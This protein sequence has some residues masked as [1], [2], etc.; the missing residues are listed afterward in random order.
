MN[1]YQPPRIENRS[2]FSWKFIAISLM[3]LIAMVNVLLIYFFAVGSV[4]KWLS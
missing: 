1:P 3:A 4:V 2:V